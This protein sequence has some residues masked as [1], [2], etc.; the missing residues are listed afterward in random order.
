MQSE[1]I[2][3]SKEKSILFIVKH[4]LKK[5]KTIIV[6]GWLCNEYMA[7]LLWT[8]MVKLRSMLATDLFFA[9]SSGTSMRSL[10]IFTIESR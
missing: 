2:K 4:S 1:G 8:A 7:D 5:D 6:L 10:S 3:K 9:C